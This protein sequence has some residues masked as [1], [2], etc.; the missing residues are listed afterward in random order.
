MILRI[1]NNLNDACQLHVVHEYSK[2]EYFNISIYNTFKNQG[3]QFKK[4]KNC[5]IQKLLCTNRFKLFESFDENSYNL[6]AL[7]SMSIINFLIVICVISKKTHLIQI[8]F[9]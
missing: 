9:F 8:F 6:R 7:S 3:A 5:K 4:R 1:I 2:I